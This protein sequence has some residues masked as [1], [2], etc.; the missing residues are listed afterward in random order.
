MKAVKYSL[1]LIVFMFLYGCSNNTSLSST[2]ESL[3][4][5][6]TPISLPENVHVE[7]VIDGDTIEFRTGDGTLHVGRLLC[8]NAPEYTKT[9][10]PYGKEATLF[11][12]NLIED[13]DIEIEYDI[14]IIDKYDRKL[15]HVKFNG[16]SVQELLLKEGLVRVAYLYNDYKYIDKYREAE[17]VATNKQINIWSKEKYVDSNNGFDI[18]AYNGY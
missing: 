18:E 17:Q 12:R 16:Q 4:T 5:S 3:G 6:I 2:I 13:K 7:R 10:Q 8:I 1:F 11:L 15:I 9:R 14:D